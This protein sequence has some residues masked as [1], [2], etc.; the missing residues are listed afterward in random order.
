ME[1]CSEFKESIYRQIKIRFS[2]G[3]MTGYCNNKDKSYYL[4]VKT[5][6]ICV[7]FLSAFKDDDYAT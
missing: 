5:Q 4:G 7:T 1:D 2:I 6:M 3:F